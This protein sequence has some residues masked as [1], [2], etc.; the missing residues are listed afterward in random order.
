MQMYN[1]SINVLHAKHRTYWD[2]YCVNGCSKYQGLNYS[3]CTC[4]LVKLQE[5]I[6]KESAI[7]SLY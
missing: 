2:L 6:T 7:P 3:T 4:V 1:I 5:F